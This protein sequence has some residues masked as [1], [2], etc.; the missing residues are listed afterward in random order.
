MLKPTNY[1]VVQFF[2]LSQF[3]RFLTWSYNVNKLDLRL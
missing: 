3:K 1:A 2:S